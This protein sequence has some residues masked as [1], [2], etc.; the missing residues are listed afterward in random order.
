[1]KK[2]SDDDNSGRNDT[3]SRNARPRVRT[4]FL[5]QKVFKMVL[6]WTLV[7][8]AWLWMAQKTYIMGTGVGTTYGGMYGDGGGKTPPLKYGIGAGYG[9]MGH[10]R[11]L[12]LSS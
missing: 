8:C 10:P 7:A 3:D 5:N 11:S 6:C 2:G 9:A 4:H 12:S 1:M